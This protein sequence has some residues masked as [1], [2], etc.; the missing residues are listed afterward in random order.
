MTWSA[1]EAMATFV[2]CRKKGKGTCSN[3]L[4]PAVEGKYDLTKERL[5]PLIP[6]SPVGPGKPRPG[7]PA[8]KDIKLKCNLQTVYIMLGLVMRGPKKKK[9]STLI[10]KVY[11]TVPLD[12][13]LIT[14]L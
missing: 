12:L 9:N 14:T 10:P 7:K 5:E 3:C 2:T 13:L 1:R 6:I 8:E 11:T 4:A